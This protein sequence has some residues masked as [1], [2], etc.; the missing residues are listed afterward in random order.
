MRRHPTPRRKPARRGTGRRPDHYRKVVIARKTTGSGTTI[1]RAMASRE[2]AMQQGRSKGGRTNAARGTAYRWDS[3][4]AREAG[5]KGNQVKHGRFNRRIGVKVGGKLV[6]RPYVKRGPLRAYYATHPTHGITYYPRLQEW[7]LC[8]I[9][10]GVFSSLRRIKEETALRRL[11]HLPTRA[12]GRKKGQISFVPT[13]IE[14]VCR[15]GK[16][17]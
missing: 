6:R 8:E 5:R 17:D 9:V 2:A 16:H 12:Q 4:A 11:G 3:A 14:V 10:D 7:L 1:V 15:K 13:G